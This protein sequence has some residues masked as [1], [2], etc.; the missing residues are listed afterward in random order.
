VDMTDGSDTPVKS[1]SPGVKRSASRH[2]AAS[3][4]SVLRTWLATSQMSRSPKYQRRLTPEDIHARL[5]FTIGL[6]LALVFLIVTAGITYALIFVTQPIGAQAPND[7]AFI[8]LLKT[9]AI[10]LTGALG[11]VLAGNGLKSKSKT[12]TP[13]DTRES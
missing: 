5:I 4:E 12:D 8:D 10:F 3:Q 7:A 9:L 13:K 6:I 2:N 11:G 1:S